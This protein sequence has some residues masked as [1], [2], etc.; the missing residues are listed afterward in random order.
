MYSPRRIQASSLAGYFFLFITYGI[1]TPYLQ[2]Y[3]R[4]RGFS[5]LEIGTLLGVLELA[6]IAGP[7]VL[8][9]LADRGSAYRALLAAC[10]LTPIAAFVPLEMAAGFV[11]ALFCIAVLGFTYRST[12]PLLDSLVSRIIPDPARRYGRLRVSGSIG[13]IAI[14]LLLQLTGIVSGASSLSI[15]LGFASTAVL[16]GAAAAFIPPAAPSPPLEGGQEHGGTGSGFD[17]KF[18]F[19]IAVIFL[20]RFGIGAYY[21]FFSLYLKDTFSLSGVSLIWAIGPLAEIPAVFFSGP[22]LARMGIRALF[23][24]SLA[25]ISVRLT[26]FIAAPSLAVVCV[27]Q[28]LHAFTFGTF[29]TTSVAYVNLKIPGAR[30]GMGMAIY[31]A[32][33]IGLPTFL[34][35]I[36]G[37]YILEGH[38]Y[39]FLFLLYAV[40]PLAGILALALFG[41]RMLAGIGFR[42]GTPPRGISP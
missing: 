5:P 31:N 28:L 17:L 15:L 36:L 25:A 10:L 8:G 16:A 13:F 24:I 11:P 37:G 21:S 27:A 32:V 26:L 40:V 33:G 14:S 2:L 4:A 1:L 12:V 41:K 38:G 6:G 42:L 23:L 22:L 29:H 35:S 9:H 34:A 3:L 20:G 19:V 7:I 39:V 30:R 18:W